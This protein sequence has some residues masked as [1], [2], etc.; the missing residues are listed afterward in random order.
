MGS[1]AIIE[2]CLLEFIGKGNSNMWICNTPLYCSSFAFYHRVL[3]CHGLISHDCNY[4]HVR[5]HLLI[6]LMGVRGWL[7]IGFSRIVGA[8]FIVIFHC[9]TDAMS[10]KSIIIGV[11]SFWWFNFISTVLLLFMHNKTQFIRF[12]YINKGY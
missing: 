2:N 1:N 10:V 6:R 4:R 5:A 7:G 8:I 11:E 9:L 12:I 3:Y